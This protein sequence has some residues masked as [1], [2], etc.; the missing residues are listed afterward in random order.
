MILKKCVDLTIQLILKFLVFFKRIKFEL[1]LQPK[2]VGPNN[3][4][5]NENERN[6]HGYSNNFICK[7]RWCNNGNV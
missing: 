1:K 7:C 6:S 5:L 3:F 2:S 4:H